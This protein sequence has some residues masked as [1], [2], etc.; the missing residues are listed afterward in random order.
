M[1]LCMKQK[2]QAG[3]ALILTMILLLVI[4]VMAIS[5]TFI[6]QTETW[7]SMNYRMMSQ[8]RD[9]AE[10]GINASSNYL[11]N[12]YTPPGTATDP[13]S[14]YQ[15]GNNVTAVQYPSSS[16]S[17]HDVIL[18]AM[19]GVSSNYPI[20]SVREAYR[21]AGQG[22]ISAGNTSLKYS[23]SARLLSMQQIAQYGS[24]SPPTMIT[25]QTWEIT[26]DGSITGLRNAQ[27]EVS[28][29]LERQ[30]A[31]VFAYAAF[32][33]SP[34][35]SALTFGGGGTT[36]S[37]NSSTGVAA[38]G[39]VTT[40]QFGGNV[41]TNG[42]L[43]TSGDP[44]TIYGTLSTP[45]T[46]VGKCT[47]GGLTAWYGHQGTV[48]G[49]LVQLPQ[50]VTYPTPTIPP[51]G[52]QDLTLNAS[53]SCPTGT[54]TISGC[55]S[56]GGNVYIPPGAYGNITV[57]SGSVLHLQAGTYD[58]NSITETGSGTVVIDSGPVI[59]NVTGN[60]IST[61]SSVVN[62]T[63]GGLVNPSLVPSNLQI[64]YAGTGN[65]SLL[66]GADAAGIV[67]APNASFGFAGGSDWYGAVVGAVM[68]DMGGTNIHYDRTL[69]TTA[70]M[71]GDYML[72]DFSWKKF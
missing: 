71:A 47:S 20:D 52:T 53:F 51:P 14:N 44:T 66:G 70:M 1:R 32:A 64:N 10:A 35:C 62:L 68:T 42:N 41:G 28:A 38:D 9:V 48:T 37:Y 30:V 21:D 4:S 69:K 19:S 56:S 5:L 40:D 61:T 55:S 6:A 24:G 11:I 12:I 63:G 50:L 67:Y 27:V 43:S 49:G 59:L 22:T 54:Y 3:V 16:S 65:I 31:P 23:T 18:S 34:T 45:R 29:I 57:T 36:D 39:T 26:S 46:G 72:Q 58:I 15:T 8:A 25:V 7:S 60:D 13:L 2:K 17:N 33:T